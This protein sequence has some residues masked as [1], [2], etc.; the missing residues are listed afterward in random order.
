MAKKNPPGGG[1]FCLWPARLVFAEEEAKQV[2]Q[3]GKEVVDAY[4]QGH[5]GHDVVGF[6][7]AHAQLC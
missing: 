1:F 7:A 4:K 5:G 3:A 6:T 2:Q